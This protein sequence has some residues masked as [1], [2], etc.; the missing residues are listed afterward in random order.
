MS[1]ENELRRDFIQISILASK[2]VWGD[3]ASE[4][5]TNA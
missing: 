1:S 4:S 2:I 3:N 5:I